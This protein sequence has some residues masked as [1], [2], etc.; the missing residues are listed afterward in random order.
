MQEEWV[1][2]CWWGLQNRTD[3]WKCANQCEETQGNNS[4]Q[5]LKFTMKL[6]LYLMNWS[7]R[8]AQLAVVKKKKK[9]TVKAAELTY[10]PR[11]MLYHYFSI[12]IA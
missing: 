1:N 9:E 2:K 5:L 3:L 4:T 7:K 11:V 10:R 6:K 8:D 12:Y